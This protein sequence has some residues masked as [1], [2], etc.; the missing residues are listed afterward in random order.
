[1]GYGVQ[2]THLIDLYKSPP[3]HKKRPPAGNV[4]QNPAIPII[5]G[6]PPGQQQSLSLQFRIAGAPFVCGQEGQ[7]QSFSSDL[8]NYGIIFPFSGT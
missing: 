3:G 5:S 4:R 8:H 2:H 6:I 7:L 1:M